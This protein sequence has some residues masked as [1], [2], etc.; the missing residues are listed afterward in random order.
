MAKMM[1][2]RREQPATRKLALA[3]GWMRRG[4]KQALVRLSQQ[5]TG[6]QETQLWASSFFPPFIGALFAVKRFI[7]NVS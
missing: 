4:H 3:V 7:V 2:W 1:T 6:A 5:L